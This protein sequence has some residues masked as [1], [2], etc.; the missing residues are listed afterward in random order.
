M[1]NKYLYRHRPIRDK[2]SASIRRI[3]KLKLFPRYDMKVI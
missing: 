2:I 3:V 1:T